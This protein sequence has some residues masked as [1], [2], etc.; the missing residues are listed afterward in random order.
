M[1]AALALIVSTLALMPSPAAIA[2]DSAAI[3][4]TEAACGPKDVKFDVKNVH[5]QP[6]AEQPETGK[7]LVYVIQDMG[8]AK[9]I[10]CPATTRVAL[11]GAWM[12]AN[13]KSSYLSFAVSPGEH[14]LCA[15]WQSGFEA[16]SP[17]V[18]LAHFSA[19]AGRI[20]YFRTRMFGNTS[21]ILFDLDPIDSDLGK[22]FVASKPLSVSHPK[23]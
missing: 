15:D 21:E 3:A 11:D 2:Q 17:I 7:A 18:G 12:G 1:R 23:K 13:H 10:G 20:Y 8:N 14:H 16:L 4:A 19:E 5:S 9:C 22:F 6:S